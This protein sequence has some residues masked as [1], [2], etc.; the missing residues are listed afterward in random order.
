[1]SIPVYRT[2]LLKYRQVY[3]G[4]DMNCLRCHAVKVCDFLY[5]GQCLTEW[6]RENVELLIDP[7]AKFPHNPTTVC[8][9]AEFCRIAESWPG[10]QKVVVIEP[11]YRD[12]WIVPPLP[13]AYCFES[14]GALVYVGA[15]KHL[16]KR[17]RGHPVRSKLKKCNR[18]ISRA[19]YAECDSWETSMDIEAWIL[20]WY[21]L[22][23]FNTARHRYR[24]S[25]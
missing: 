22:P 19:V 18:N 6:Q 1:M 2:C 5:C 16:N 3:I 21:K 10:V 20:G 13:A 17:F 11:G 15:S 25:A 9:M 12:S 4:I 7:S 14:D 24:K 23:L 8:D